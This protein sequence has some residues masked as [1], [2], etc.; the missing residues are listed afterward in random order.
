V[1]VIPTPPR[2]LRARVKA[3][4]AAITTAAMVTT[5]AV[6]VGLTS[7]TFQAEVPDPQI[8]AVEDARKV[9]DTDVALTSA[10]LGIYGVGPIFRIAGL[11][12]FSPEDIISTLL[13]GLDLPLSD[14][15]PEAVDTGVLGPLPRSVYNAVNGL[16]YTADGFRS[17]VL[18][19]PESVLEVLTPTLVEEYDLDLDPDAPIAAVV[20]ALIDKFP[21]L[22]Q[23]RAFLL[24]A[25]LGG[26]TTALAYRQMIDAVTSDSPDWGPGVTGQLL[27]FLNSPSRPGGG[28]LALFSPFTNIFGLNLSTPEAGSY[29]NGGVRPTKILNT[30]ILDVSWSYNAISDAPTVLNPLAW[31]NALAGSVFLTALI[32]DD[33]DLSRT[34]LEALG[35]EAAAAAQNALAVFGDLTGGQ[36]LA[37]VPVLADLIR[38]LEDFGVPVPD[39][40]VGKGESHYLT[41]DSGNLPLLEPFDLL[42]RLLGLVGIN[43]PQPF[44]NSIENAL[45]K[46]INL[47]YQDVDPV[48][49]ERRFDMGGEQALLWHEPLTPTQRFEAQ[50]TIVN[51]LVDDIQANLLNP[52]A[53]VPSVRGLDGLNAVLEAVI[54][55]PVAM[56]VAAAVNW[57]ID[58]LQDVANRV[59]D[60]VQVVATPFL[61]AED[62]ASAQF[63]KTIDWLLGVQSGGAARPS[64]SAQ[65]LLAAEVEGP[66]AD[67]SV[68]DVKEA[69]HERDS[70]QA[71]PR[72]DGTDDASPAK[73]SRATLAALREQRKAVRAELKEARALARAEVDTSADTVEKVADVRKVGADNSGGD[74]VKQPAASAQERKAE[75]AERRAAHRGLAQAG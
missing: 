22:N 30:S 31:L 23:R 11:L 70:V 16:S 5:A 28:A 3:K 75:R 51:T 62:A 24:S 38:I 69:G 42:P 33:L 60:V 43:V 34:N 8:A 56:A 40:P 73:D 58:I 48:T 37:A 53:W 14:L 7:P 15:D 9:V 72:V 66:V 36:G 71:E 47:S 74:T 67:A 64:G 59:Y 27:A 57:G 18:S 50:Q 52:Q 63:E 41:Y 39:L 10:A 29:T 61:N 26:L 46:L 55:N 54:A 13:Q 32:P 21:I 6:T 1:S 25:G 4:A 17:L 2:L 65:S 68:D 20:Q 45:R 44:V 12:G 49:L 19:L 35:P